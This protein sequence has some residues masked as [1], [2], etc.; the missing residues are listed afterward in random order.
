MPSTLS[1]FAASHREQLLFFAK[2][3]GIYVAWYVFYELWL[4]PD[5]RLDRWLSHNVAA[6]GGHLLALLGVEATAEG[7][8]LWVAAAPGVRVVNGCNGL[9]TIGLFAGFVFAFPGSSPR[10]ALFLPLGIGVIYMANVARVAGLAALQSAWPEVF[11]VVH[12]FG[13][14]TIFYLVVFALWMVW[15]NYGRPPRTDRADGAQTPA[16][17]QQGL[18]DSSPV[19]AS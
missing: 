2:L 1:R 6:V 10:R 7:R 16:A 9:S 3:L 4:L 18:T 12:D 17:R 8:V 19:P 5:G 13:T 14:T 11:D 15:A